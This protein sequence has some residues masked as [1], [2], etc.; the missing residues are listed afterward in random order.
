V[1]FYKLT[2]LIYQ[3]ESKLCKISTI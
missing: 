2:T 1:K 3:P